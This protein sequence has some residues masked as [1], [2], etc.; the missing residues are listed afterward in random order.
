MKKESEKNPMPIIVGSPRSGTT[1]LRLMLDAH[2]EMAIPPETG[3]LAAN[4]DAKV[5]NNLEKFFQMVTSYPPD[6]PSWGDFQISKDKFYSELKKLNPFTVAD[7]FRLFYK[8][9]AD[10]FGKSRWGDKTPLYA[11]HLE[12]L[13]ELLPE[14]HFIH[15]IRDGRDSAVSLRKCW[16]SPGYDIET[17][18]S[19]W[20]D[21]VLTA[22]TQEKKC[23]H[24]FEVRYED[25]VNEPYNALKRICL[26]LDLGFD[27]KMLEYYKY[28]PERIEE[29]QG[30]YRDNGEIILSKEDRL[31]QQKSSTLP[32]K[33]EKIGEWKNLLSQK[34]NERFKQIAGDLL[35]ELGYNT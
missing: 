8:M 19:F 11:R 21:N 9:Y 17:Q 7:G 13:Q 29:H 34:E 32:L 2:P 3:F 12:Y 24:Y 18:A 4:K 1:L 6:Q 23:R 22:R 20:R 16:F 30:R 10:R 14:A 35:I 33:K 31:K 5:G 25:L 28:A 27:N 26:F 15:I